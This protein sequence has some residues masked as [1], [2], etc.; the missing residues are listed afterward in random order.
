MT[1]IAYPSTPS[2]SKIG[3][4][5]L[6]QGFQKTPVEGSAP[7]D[8]SNLRKAQLEAVSL[9]AAGVVKLRCTVT[10]SAPFL[11]APLLGILAVKTVEASG[12]QNYGENRSTFVGPATV[13][14][15][16]IVVDAQITI[17]VA[18]PAANAIEWTITNAAAGTVSFDVEAVVM[19]G[20]GQV[21]T[22]TDAS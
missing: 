1:D 21:Y 22:F 8:V 5:F 9:A 14:A 6:Y 18:S 20:N 7:L 16:P 10:G 3:N 11:S 15:G 19:G 2:S 12:T 4:R 13:V 17:A